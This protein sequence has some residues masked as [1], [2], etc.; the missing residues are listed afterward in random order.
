MENV[1]LISPCT[2]VTSEFWIGVRDS[3]PLVVGVIPFGITCGIMAL[4]AGLTGGEAIAMSM[5]VFAGAAQFIAITMLGAGIKGFGIIVFTTLLINLRHLL[6][7]ASLAPYI[8]R[9]PL[10]LQ[11][12][13]SFGM[14][15]ETY[16][17]TIDRAQ[18]TGYNASYQLGAT[19]FFYSAWI[20]S[21][22]VGVLLSGYI[23]DPLAWGL[24]FAMPA[25]FLSMLIPRLV[26]PAAMAVCGA[27][28][29]VAI[30][31]VLYLPGK[32]YIIAACLTATAVGGLM[33]ERV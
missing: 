24:D 14:V 7:G 26:S 22:A 17:I 4:T 30:I 21:T 18:K 8:I 10:S 13:L 20:L 11:V 23:L 6:M 16:A 5:F 9:L 12:L 27:A 15:D 2:K 3:V 32:W 25:I 28:A 19:L 1:R 29:A 33:E 31:G